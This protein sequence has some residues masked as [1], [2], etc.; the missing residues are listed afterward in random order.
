MGGLS[1]ETDQSLPSNLEQGEQQERG[2]LHFLSNRGNSL[3]GRIQAGQ[4]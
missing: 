4:L 2:S 3:Y 1:G